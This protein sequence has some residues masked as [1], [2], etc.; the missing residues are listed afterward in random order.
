MFGR[1]IRRMT[2]LL[3]CELEKIAQE[4]PHIEELKEC[5]YCNDNMKRDCPDYRPIIKF[6]NGCYHG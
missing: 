1:D 2:K 4:S 5:K 3:T 6:D